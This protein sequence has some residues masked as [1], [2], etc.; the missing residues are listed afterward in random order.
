MAK[1]QSKLVPAVWGGL[2]IGVISGVPVLNF[3]NCACCAGVIAGGILAVYI[4]RNNIDPTEPLIMGD[5][6]VLGLLAGVF[7]AVI[8]SILDGLFGVMTYDFLLKASEYIDDPELK[9]I[10]ESFDPKIMGPGIFILGFLFDLVIDCVFGLLGG[11]LGIA[12]L[13]KHVK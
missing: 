4:Y 7:G 1:Q 3:I 2:L 10:L 6:A 11:L 13:V 8:G 12:L 5:G 9:G